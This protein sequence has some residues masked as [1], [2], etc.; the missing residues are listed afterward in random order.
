MYNNS[1]ILFEENTSIS[2]EFYKTE[3]NKGGNRYVQ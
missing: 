3:E 1:I 2:I